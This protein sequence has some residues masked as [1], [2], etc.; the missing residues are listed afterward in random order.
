MKAGNN[1]LTSIEAVD[2]QSMVAVAARALRQEI[3]SRPDDDMFLGSEDEL[4]AR[5]AVS[6]PTFRQ[7]ARLLEF[8]ELI[9]VKRGVGGGYFGRKPTASVVARLAGIY[10]QSQGATF[11]DVTRVQ[12]ILEGEVIRLLIEERS[13]A[14]RRALTDSLDLDND[15][16]PNVEVSRG[17]RAINYF[18]RQAGELSGSTST[19]LFMLASQAYGATSD[20]LRLTPAR[21]RIYGQ[22][23]AEL[24]R[25][26]EAC[27]LERA[28]AIRAAS[29]HNIMSWIDEDTSGT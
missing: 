5:L 1:R 21:I 15:F 11:R 2:S 9:Y 3:L 19:A 8:E 14:D 18:W 25:A 20:K 13:A 22:G 6:P 16:A 4:V 12:A 28:L 26:I 10:L 17:V 24:C 29:Y 7:A 23:L 27:D